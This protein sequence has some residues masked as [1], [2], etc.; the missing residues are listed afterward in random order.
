M[1]NWKP[2]TI[3]GRIAN[4]IDR[5]LGFDEV[6]WPGP[7]GGKEYGDAGLLLSCRITLSHLEASLKRNRDLRNALVVKLSD[8]FNPDYREIHDLVE[9]SGLSYRSVK[10]VISRGTNTN[11]A[12]NTSHE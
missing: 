4:L 11:P 10:R 12:S 6:P 8:P 9:L 3:G 2:R 1:P 5:M 7:D